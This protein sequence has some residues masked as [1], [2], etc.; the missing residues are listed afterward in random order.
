MTFNV[1]VKDGAGNPVPNAIVTATNLVNG[2]SFPRGT[3]GSG[4]ANVD[5][6]ATPVATLMMLSVQ[7]EGF[8]NSIQYP[9]TTSTDQD[10]NIVL[11]SFNRPFKA[12]PR[13]WKGNFCGVRIPGAPAVP[14]GASDSSLILSW[15]YDRYSSEFRTVIRANWKAKGQTHIVTSWP[16]SRS[17]GWS[18]EEFV[19]FNKELMDDGFFPCPFL[20]SKDHD[21]ADPV[22][23]MQ[24]LD[25]SGV[26]AKLKAAGIPMICI[27]WELSL[28]LQPVEVQM[29]I[30]AIC[31]IFV[32]IG[33]RVYVHFQE[34]YPSFQ[35]A[36]GS[37]A[38]FWWPQVGKLTGI[39]YQKRQAQ[40]NTEFLDS[41]SDCLQRFCGG[42]GM[43]SDSGFGHPFDFVCMELS[44]MDAFWSGWTEAQQNAL[45]QVAINAPH[46]F[47]PDGTEAYVMGS[48][49]GF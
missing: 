27:G 13:F 48:G 16:D 25:S 38:D 9:T 10:V 30:D 39:L 20:S 21:P 47:G 18:A 32:P 42:W 8:V 12:A 6:K 15:F 5:V 34:G 49:N 43:P 14:G 37:V 3:D 23:I 17:F 45:G 28:W 24:E 33:T 7:C 26:L 44:A 22:Q 11:V 40:N 2:A 35:K 31:P 36:G 41:I 29:L 4:Y 46:C 1:R 19:N